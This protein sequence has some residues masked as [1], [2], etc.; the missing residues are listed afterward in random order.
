VD[1]ELISMVED[2]GA[3]SAEVVSKKSSMME[4]RCKRW[5]RFQSLTV[6]PRSD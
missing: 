5:R 6:L 1:A 4:A 2:A 3:E